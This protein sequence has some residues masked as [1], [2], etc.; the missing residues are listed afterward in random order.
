ML[1][2]TTINIDDIYKRYDDED[3]RRRVR[4]CASKSQRVRRDVRGKMI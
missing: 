2:A 4:V 3:D 1:K